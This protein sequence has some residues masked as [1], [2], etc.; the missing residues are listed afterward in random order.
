MTDFNALGALVALSVLTEATVQIFIKDTPSPLNKY[1]L[2]TT[3][4]KSQGMV[5]WIS[6]LI[7][8]AYAYNMGLDIFIILGYKSKLPYIGPIATGLIASRGSN[9]L[10]EII[11]NLN[12]RNK[13]T[14]V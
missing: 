7:G 9:Y 10:H 3:Y 2:S 13:E 11:M 14:I 1:I 4:E 8:I 12:N 6:A 5:R